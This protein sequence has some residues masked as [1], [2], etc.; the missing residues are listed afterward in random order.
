M[1]LKWRDILRL[2]KTFRHP[3]HNLQLYTMTTP[4]KQRET[5]TTV[6]DTLHS[7]HKPPA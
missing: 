2:K 6:S 4:K 5:S 3:L 7:L 1:F